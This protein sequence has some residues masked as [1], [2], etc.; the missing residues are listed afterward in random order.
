MPLPETWMP[1]RRE[2][3]ELVGWIVPQGDGFVTH[4][5]LGRARQEAP[6]DWLDAEEDLENLGIGYLAEIYA[7]RT[8]AGEWV[9]VRVVEVSTDGIGLK[10]DDFGDIGAPVSSYRLPFP[11]G[12]RLVPLADAPAPVRSLMS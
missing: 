9:R 11:V 8:G 12:D 5:L 2:D 1:Q 7:L 6:L 10:D 3:G 4:D